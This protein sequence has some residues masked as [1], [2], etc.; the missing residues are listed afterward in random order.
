VVAAQGLAEL[1]V[2]CMDRQPSPN[3]K[4]LRNVA[5]MACGD[6]NETPTAPPE[7]E[8]SSDDEDGDGERRMSNGQA[9]SS[10]RAGVCHANACCENEKLATSK[11]GKADE[12]LV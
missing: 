6:P 5:A 11:H 7:S 8:L 3:D 10:G 12:R 2:R 9:S 1:I 4:I